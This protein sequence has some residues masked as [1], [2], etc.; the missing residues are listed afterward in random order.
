MPFL[1][2]EG[3]ES[4]GEYDTVCCKSRSRSPRGKFGV[5]AVFDRVGP[6]GVPFT[7]GAGEPRADS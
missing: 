2:E 4:A 7:E 1:E 3:V 6:W 5:D